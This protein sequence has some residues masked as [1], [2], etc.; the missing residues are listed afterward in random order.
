MLYITL[1]NLKIYYVFVPSMKIQQNPADVH[2]GK[3]L[4]ENVDVLS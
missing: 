1:Q 3:T 2:R 4:V